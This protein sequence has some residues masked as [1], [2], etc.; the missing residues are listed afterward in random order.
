M[1]LGLGAFLSLLMLSL[2][3]QRQ[4]VIDAYSTR[5]HAV[6]SL[7]I[8][9]LQ[10]IEDRRATGV[11]SLE[12]AQAEAKE[13]LSRLRYEDGEYL[14]A[15]DRQAVMVVNPAR[16]ELVGTSLLEFRD[17]DGNNLAKL[18]K[19]ALDQGEATVRYVF[20]RMQ[21]GAPIEKI[22]YGM[23]F[24]PWGWLVGS[25]VYLEDA[26]AAFQRGAKHMAAIAVPLTGA[27]L[28]V[29]FWLA[30]SVAKSVRELA[31]VVDGVSRRRYDQPIP[32]TGRSD[33]LGQLAR[34]VAALQKVAGME[35]ELRR[36][37]DLV[38]SVF[39]ASE[40]AAAVCD[41]TGHILFVSAALSRMTGYDAG[42]LEGKSLDVL[43]SGHQDDEF[44]DQ[45]ESHLRQ[46]GYWEGDAWYRRANGQIL[47]V[48]K[49]V[50]AIRGEDG[51]VINTV[52]IM[53]DVVERGRHQ[54]SQ[55]FLPMHDPLTNDG[56]LLGQRLSRSLALTARSGR[57]TG[58]VLVDVD[59]F[60]RVNQELGM[61]GGDE[62]LRFLA[63]RLMKAVRSSD[64]VAR[65][66]GDEYAVLMEDVQSSDEIRMVVG[67]IQ[68]A[69]RA[70]LV[71]GGHTC[72][73][74]V[75]IGVAVAPDHGHGQSRMLRSAQEALENAQQD[76]GDRVAWAS[77]ALAVAE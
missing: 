2:Y 35:D 25:G 45:V 59:D 19:L 23:S 14:F 18:A 49:R 63:L 55:R 50:T 48:H 41:A 56:Q 54:R 39:D 22:S 43:R 74:S 12:Q 53:R 75:S 29:V 69:M 17:A 6:V 31:Q 72:A 68:E 71:V 66:E 13:M 47:V 57:P 28:L 27:L 60:A 70:P 11:I 58:L 76:G 15:V 42:W 9:L 38:A 64:T 3:A 40:E 62:A 37:R 30:R 73:L 16:P 8:S 61:V 10:Q 51:A 26:E 24:R 67:R 21:G 33:E 77:Q 7:A 34:A 46:Q 5:S 52:A 65:L 20:T 1:I 44:F 4:A 36:S 32:H